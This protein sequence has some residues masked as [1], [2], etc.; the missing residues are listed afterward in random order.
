M[1]GETMSAQTTEADARILIDDLLKEA[2]W[3][4]A[5]KSQVLTEFYIQQADE[6]LQS[7]WDIMVTK[8][9]RTR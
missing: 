3:D 1:K 7:P 6:R 8:E 4:P 2:R 5:D 9:N